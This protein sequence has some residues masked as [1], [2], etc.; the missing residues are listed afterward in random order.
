MRVDKRGNTVCGGGGGDK[1]SKPLT[2]L[3]DVL[4]SSKV[5]QA[6]LQHK[7][8]L[9]AAGLG[10]GRTTSAQQRTRDVSKPNELSLGTQGVPLNGK[11]DD[12]APR[13]LEL[14]NGVF[15]DLD[16]E[17]LLGQEAASQEV[18]LNSV[19]SRKSRKATRTRRRATTCVVISNNMS[20]TAPCSSP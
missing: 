9:R 6:A 12:S 5:G 2:H 10:W 17:G 8:E 20:S 4:G 14:R 3:C 16:G 7:R 11:H 13:L 19:R 1:H 15:F 18:L